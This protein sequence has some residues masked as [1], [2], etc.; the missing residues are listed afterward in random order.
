MRWVDVRPANDGARHVDVGRAH[1]RRGRVRPR[2]EMDG[3]KPWFIRRKQGQRPSGYQGRTPQGHRHER[4]LQRDVGHLSACGDGR[5]L[6][7]H[8]GD[9]RTIRAVGRRLV[10][11]EPR[12]PTTCERCRRSGAKWLDRAMAMW[13]AAEDSQVCPL[14]QGSRSRSPRGEAAVAA[15]YSPVSEVLSSAL[16]A[17]HA[18]SSLPR[19][20]PG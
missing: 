20:G 2:G 13:R 8:F 3:S 9:Q 1:R 11:G 15:T 7:P 10:R 5:V 14:L 19:A 16:S 4:W 12:R 18:L 17:Q 6:P